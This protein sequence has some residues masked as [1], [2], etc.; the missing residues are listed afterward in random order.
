MK[1]YIFLLII[2]LVNLSLL[3]QE[4]NAFKG[5]FEIKSN[6]LYTIFETQELSFEKIITDEH[7]I[8]ISLTIPIDDETFKF[9]FLLL[10][11]YRLYY[12]NRAS[13]FFLEA[14]FAFASY[15]DYTNIMIP[16]NT[17]TN[18][19]ND[20]LKKKTNTF[21]IGFGAG[22]G[23]KFLTNSGWIGEVLIGGGRKLTKY[24]SFYPHWGISIGKRF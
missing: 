22:V 15:D 23:Y 2:G 14:N 1:K 8:G 11:Y 3:A 6:A 18:Y 17:P 10:P 13:G 24:W 7:S 5:M 21:K 16:D 19:D 9:N 4:K 20:Y 12:G